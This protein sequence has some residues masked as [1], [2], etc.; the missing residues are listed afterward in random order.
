MNEN[1]PE[2]LNSE[3]KNIADIL[4]KYVKYW[5]LFAI[6][7]VIC[8]SAI[9][10]Y[11]RYKA[12]TNY[13]ISS[14]IFIKE[15][16]AGQSVNENQGFN[17]LGLIKTSHSID[18]EIGIL[19]SSGIMEKVISKLNLN[20]AYYVE[21]KIRDVEIYGDDV[22]VDILVDETS[23]NLAF[24]LP[25]YIKLLTDDTY[26]IISEYDGQSI[27]SEHKFGDLVSEPFGTITVTKKED[28][29]FID[30][31]KPLYFQ[32]KNKDRL[33]ID[34]LGRLGIA[35]SNKGGNLLNISFL[36]SSKQKGEDIVAGLIETYVEE[37][38]KYENEIAENTIQMIDDRLTKLSSEIEGVESN[39]ENFKS[40]NVITDVASNANSFIGQAND[41]KNRISEYQ[42][43]INVLGYVEESFNSG[44]ADAT[45]SS[46]IAVND[47]VLS[48]MVNTYNETLMEK[49]RLAQSTPSSNP[50]IV[51]LD[52]T[53][54][55]L[56][57]SILQNVRSTK[58]GLLIAQR[59]LQSNAN[60]YQAQIARV[61][62]MERKLSDI[63]REQSTKEGL[64]LYLLQKREEEV[65]SMAAP[66]S[67]TRI[68][69]LPKAS[70]YPVSPNKV[71][72]YLGGLLL[73]LFLP[74]C[75]V[76]AKETLN[77]NISSLDEL[78][79]LSMAPVLGEISKNKTKTSLI[80]SERERTPTA[81]LFRLLRF[82]LEYLK[83]NDKNQ[84]LMVTSSVKGEGKTFVAANLAI[85]LA[86]AGEK[87][88]LL[89]FDLREP[90]LMPLFGLSEKP[91]ITDFIVKKG[92]PLNEIIQ[93][94]KD[95][96]NLNLIGAGIP[97]I[98]VGKLILNERIE[99]LLSQLKK[100]YDR[101]IIDTAPIGKVSDGFALNPYID[102]TIYVVR[103]GF[104]KKEYLKTL[105]NIYQQNKLRNT[106]VL[107][108]DT[109]S[110]QSYGYGNK[111][112]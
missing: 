5:P 11:I 75:I 9:F 102:S 103:Q 74:F 65:L 17:N 106:M 105:N 25:I 59:N 16:A 46:S 98:E 70:L 36:S 33:V 67:S 72:L 30:Q 51:D 63:S 87:V 99:T 88:V 44:G 91:G 93:T 34:F 18:D 73:G 79:K 85:S 7:I 95:I 8:L 56:R 50:I 58:N 40:R 60:K 43:Q 68:V 84:T 45:I 35:P 92:M 55:N 20:V 78:T 104:S 41:Y 61:P 112:Y 100:D 23:K 2:F 42:S 3:E 101:I 80:A 57:S 90:A 66:V 82:N 89:S 76:F 71:S 54:T 77:N 96:E 27:S 48:N 37:T 12:D 64:F 107:L 39:V 62:S 86:S 109:S 13:A 22:P 52:T 19:K 29:N 47:G 26:Q 111:T 81:E 31:G 83:K 94:N 69:S 108:N 21:G 6:G 1:K 49:K 110:G 28:T 38:I 53:L 32:I 10:L 4:K 24:N 14:T 15:T 97:M